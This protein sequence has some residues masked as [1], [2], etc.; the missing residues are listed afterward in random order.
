[1]GQPDCQNDGAACLSEQGDSL[2]V[3]TMG[4]PDCQNKAAACLSE[5]GGSLGI[6]T[7]EQLVVQND[8]EMPPVHVTPGIKMT[9]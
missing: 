9:T 4:Q 2:F 1:M 3:R 7:V 8:D 6:R 5:Y